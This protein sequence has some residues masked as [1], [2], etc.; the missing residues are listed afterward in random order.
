MGV[1]D[2]PACRGGGTME[3]TLD[4]IL[5]DELDFSESSCGKCFAS[6]RHSRKRGKW[7]KEE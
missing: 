2:D 4:L 7:A 5:K 6:S 3:K 1:T